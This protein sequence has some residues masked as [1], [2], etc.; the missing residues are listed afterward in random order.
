MRLVILLAAVL[1]LGGCRKDPVILA[2]G[3]PIA[4]WVQAL[5]DPNPRSRKKAADVLG[6]VGAVDPAV[7]PA[8]ARALKDRDAGVRR[9]AQLH[10]A[11]KA[12]WRFQ[13]MLYGDEPGEPLLAKSGRDWD[14]TEQAKVRERAGL[15]SGFR[16][17][18][19]SV[20]LV[21][22]HAGSTACAPRS[23]RCSRREPEGAPVVVDHGK[24]DRVTESQG[25]SPMGSA[26]EAFEQA[27]SG[28]VPGAYELVLYVAGSAPRSLRAVATV[29]KLCQEYLPDR[30]ALEV[31]DIYQQPSL[32][33]E[34][35]V[36]A[37]PSA[38]TAIE[39]WLGIGGVKFDFVD[40]LPERRV[41]GTPD[42][43]AT[44]SLRDA[45]DRTPFRLVVPPSDLGRYT[46][47]VHEPPRGF[48]FSVRA[49]VPL[50]EATQKCCLPGANRS[51]PPL[52]A[53]ILFPKKSEMTVWLTPTR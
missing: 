19:V 49:P 6:N 23:F 29:R 15:P 9:A 48:H 3:K 34:A 33:E 44:I 13:F 45:Q 21:R 26:T 11:G 41:V 18:F 47:Y 17:E 37:V 10:D 52:T 51:G 27:L 32:A 24:E 4:H 40:K 31:V 5:Q 7:V 35:G 50:D 22:N 43:G 12:D 46:L 25:G 14:A 20:A 39:R 42:L 16:H 2:H 1:L 38:R 30:H 36:L 28:R 8:L 53:C